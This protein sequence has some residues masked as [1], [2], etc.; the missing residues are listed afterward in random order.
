VADLATLPET[1]DIIRKLNALAVEPKEIWQETDGS[2]EM[3]K[4]VPPSVKR[5]MFPVRTK[6][7]TSKDC[8]SHLDLRQS[9]Q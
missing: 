9:L 5:G 3:S 2:R 7:S 4:G 6:H 1:V 8:P